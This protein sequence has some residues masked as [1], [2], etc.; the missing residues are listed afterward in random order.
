[1]TFTELL[2]DRADALGDAD[3]QVFLSDPGGARHLTYAELDRRARALAVRLREH[4]AQGQPVLLLYPQGAEFLVGFAGCLYA[5]AVAVPAPLPGDRGERLQ[6]VSGI[7]KDTGA[8]LVLTD[9][10]HAADTSLWLAVSGRGE[11]VCLATDLDEA[12]PAAWRAPRTGPDDLAF[13]QY[14]SGS[15][16]R[17]R[18]VMVTHR[19]LL[20]NQ[21]ALQHL[22]GTSAADRFTSWL[23][24][25]HDM[26]LIAHVLHPLW[27]G[28]FCVQLPSVSFI[29]RPISWL[30]SIGEYGLTVGG[31]PNF[32]YDLCTRRVTD[33]QLAELDLTSWRLALCGAEPVRAATLDAFAR[34]F[35]PAGLRAESLYPGY[36]LAEATLVVSGGEPGVAARR[37]TVDAAALEQDEL[38]APRPG[39]ATRTLVGNGRAPDFDVRIVDPVAGR[40]LPAG[41]VGEIWLRGESTA[42]GYWRQPL[43]SAR[44]FH[45]TLSRA[46]LD[47]VPDG[48]PA[49]SGAGGGTPRVAFDA[50]SAVRPTA[51]HAA[52]AASGATHP[53]GTASEG[54]GGEGGTTGAASDARPATA[55]AVR[56]AVS[57]ASTDGAAGDASAAP[58]A[59]A[60]D[61]AS[62]AARPDGA[63]HDAPATPR[64]PHPVFGAAGG[65][66]RCPVLGVTGTMPGHAAAHRPAPSAVPPATAT[67][68]ATAAA[69]PPATAVTA[70]PE[71]PGGFLRTGDLGAFQDGELYITGRLKE[72]IILNGRN[73]YPQDVEWA[74]RDLSPALGAGHGAVFT[75]DADR[76]QLVV[77]HEVRAPRADTERLRALARRI[78]SLVGQNFDV[79]AANIT[80]LRPGTLRRT[81]SGKIQRTLMRRLF[82]HGQLSPLYEVLDPAVRALIQPATVPSGD[83]ARSTSW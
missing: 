9:A 76:E 55:P 24:H 31:G 29:K 44:T 10:E 66:G 79:P 61:A 43:E 62:G 58:G 75:V 39:A 2:R 12:D 20:A 67:A 4:G 45:A 32:C 63:P 38:R 52:D 77:V 73:I 82:L 1:M 69:P 80:L 47:G 59:E 49:E 65:V 56:T 53:D 50:R 18:G 37:L 78:Q 72:V 74:I 17:P 27:L 64:I 22:L 42:Q 13:L 8:R 3:A 48:S 33:A 70:L 36:G 46:G 21:E 60:A 28:T 35:A 7:L 5:G 57:P 40:E 81:T 71:A 34:R 19:N 11:T 25:Y 41:R 30:R 16:S 6:R 83:P 68:T 51:L 14:T 23:P 15:T 26:G 54:P